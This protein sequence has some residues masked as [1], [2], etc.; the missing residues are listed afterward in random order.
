MRLFWH[1]RELEDFIA[2]HPNVLAPFGIF[3][4]DIVVLG[5]QVPTHVGVLDLLCLV[6]KTICVVEIKAK[7]A[8]ARDVDQVMRYAGY[9][10]RHLFNF[11][12]EAN[13]QLEDTTEREVRI[14]WEM[15]R[16]VRDENFMPVQPMVV[17]PG[18][19]ASAERLN[20]V[21]LFQAKRVGPGYEITDWRSSYS[22][23][24]EQAL[25]G[26]LRPAFDLLYR[27][28]ANIVDDRAET[29][30]LLERVR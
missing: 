1:E 25:K 27:V 14:A 21:H 10:K 9:L 12:V 7:Q 17:A 5:R 18:F 23:S 30:A 19:A 28:A 4:D 20:G 22:G 3:G 26:R 29:H 2:A 13:W 11:M 16:M 24:D 8:T 6:D 15:G